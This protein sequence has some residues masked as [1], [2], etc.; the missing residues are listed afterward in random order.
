M[1]RRE[2]SATIQ[3]L[4]EDEFR[5]VVSNSSV[6]RDRMRILT[7]G[8]DYSEYMASSPVL[9]F[10]TTRR[11]RSAAASRCASSATICKRGFNSPRSASPT[12]PIEREGCSNAS[13]RC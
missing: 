12:P 2:Y 8:L 1:I 9:L 13:R 3:A 4:G 6:G 11:S 10:S 7:S 5:A